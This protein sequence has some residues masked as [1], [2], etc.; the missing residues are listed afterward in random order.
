[1]SQNEEKIISYL[2]QIEKN[3][4]EIRKLIEVSI[5]Y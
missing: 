5:F 2:E 3:T 1:M 4:E